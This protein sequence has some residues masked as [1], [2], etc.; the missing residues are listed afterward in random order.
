MELPRQ[1]LI[2]IIKGTCDGKH[3][4]QWGAK[5][6]ADLAPN[7]W[8]FIDCSGLMDYTLRRAW[9]V[10]M[11]VGGSVNQHAWCEKKCLKQVDYK[12]IPTL[13]VGLVLLCYMN[14]NGERHTWAVITEEPGQ[15]IL[16][17]ESNGDHGPC[18]EP[19][20]IYKDRCSACFVLGSL[21]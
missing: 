15:P 20:T 19:W 4:Y 9:G 10:K 13:P 11:D 7:Q 21:V 14:I 18:R 12:D 6:S 3:R 1:P 17:F 2:D 5:Q 8:E 16:T